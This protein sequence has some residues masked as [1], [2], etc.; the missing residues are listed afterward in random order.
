M[1]TLPTELCEI[2]ASYKEAFEEVERKIACAVSMYNNMEEKVH[3]II[4]N[5]E[6]YRF[7]PSYELQVLR[8]IDELMTQAGNIVNRIYE[9]DGVT[10]TQCK[11]LDILSRELNGD[12]FTILSYPFYLCPLSPNMV[13]EAVNNSSW[14]EIY[15]F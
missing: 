4:S 11:V 14:D 12:L 13:E 7:T 6:S 8:H 9:E 2:V 3:F 5:I 1:E 15:F 10:K